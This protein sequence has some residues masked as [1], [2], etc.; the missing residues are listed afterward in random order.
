MIT[1]K[2]IGIFLMREFLLIGND[3]SGKPMRVVRLKMSIFCS[4]L[5]KH[6]RVHEH[7]FIKL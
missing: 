3:L 5:I 2:L 4:C 6:L 7:K 1:S